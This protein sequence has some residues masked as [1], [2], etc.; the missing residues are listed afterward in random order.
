M[1][2]IEKTI[3]FTEP[4]IS[5]LLFLSFLLLL[6]SFLFRRYSF[7]MTSLGLVLALT[8]LVLGL[9]WKMTLLEA[10]CYL[11]ICLIASIGGHLLKEKM[12]DVIQ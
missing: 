4:W 9:L 5:G 6:L 10:G 7:I 12:N 8:G 1:E 3:F 11:V 2:A